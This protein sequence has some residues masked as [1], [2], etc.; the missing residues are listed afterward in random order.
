MDRRAMEDLGLS[1][2]VLMENAAY[3]VVEAV[4]DTFPEVE[5]VAIFCGPGNNGGDGLAVGRLLVTRGYDMVLYLVSGGRERVGK[6]LAGDA[7]IQLEACRRLN[8]EIWEIYDEPTTA[9]ALGAT[10]TGADLVVDALFGT[11]LRR[12]LREVFAAVVEGLNRL[13]T[14]VLAVDL[15]SGLD[16]SLAAPIGPH[17]QA[18][19]TVTFAA[20]KVAH[21]FS[22]AAEAVGKLA[23]TD[24]GFPVSW[25]E[26][27]Q[28]FE[29]QLVESP[30]VKSLSVETR[31]HLMLASELAAYVQPR[32]I[33]GHKGTFGHLLVG[34][35]S[36][37]KAGAAVLAAQG[38]VRGGAGLVTVAVP[39]SLM[40]LV[41]AASL[42]SM[43]VPLE[44]GE[45]G[46]LAMAAVE[47]WLSLAQGK[48]A[49]ALG[50]GLAPR[51]PPGADRRDV[52]AS[53]SLLS[54]GE[55]PPWAT[56]VRAMVLG[57]NAPLV[58]DADGINA[59]AGRAAELRQRK[60]P[61][62]LTPHP[63][64]LA[65]LLSQPVPRTA[66]ERCGA[67]RLAA[68]D[69]GAVVVLKGHQ[70]LVAAPEGEIYLNSTGNAGMATG[71]SGDVLTGL[72]GAL[73]AQGYEALAAAQV[74]VFLHGDAGD[75]GV[76]RLGES[77]FAARDLLEE[78]GSAQ[79]SLE[80]A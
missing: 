61:L 50:P 55:S 33:D 30:S 66:E 44:A 3:G 37:G 45:E 60:S 78:L 47:T 1:G 79:L 6:A 56:A 46:A 36:P 4:A 38:A 35:G 54:A 13:A 16:A 62:V 48:S 63:G 12:P 9:A 41:D 19:M 27:I 14:P 32:P 53:K 70:T 28:P 68:R 52:A 39:E 71:G 69:T 24:L 18:Q 74:G 8:L 72:I 11:G 59:F 34:A 57:S 21:V 75:R 20:P 22:P 42:E 77:A 5:S 25:I 65:R 2:L 49:L 15:P 29:G 10:A 73:L 58:L 76:R 23:V 51:S 31:L 40:D 64:E 7:A 67:A 80:R 43:T 17:V 26:E